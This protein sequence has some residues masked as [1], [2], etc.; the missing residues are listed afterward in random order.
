VPA[1]RSLDF[2]NYSG[3][4]IKLIMAVVAVS[5][6]ITLALVQPS[7]FEPEVVDVLFVLL[8]GT[9][10]GQ[11][12]FAAIWSALGPGAF[13]WRTVGSLLWIG[14]LTVGLYLNRGLDASFQW[15]LSRQI[16]LP[17]L[18]FWLVLQISLLT[19]AKLTAL[20]VVRPVEGTGVFVVRARQFTNR[21]LLLFIT[22]LAV[23][24]GAARFFVTVHTLKPVGGLVRVDFAV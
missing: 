17:L 15:T 7:R 3:S 5:S 8:I 1:T 11:S 20:R 6:C 14:G 21:E 18:A 12:I 4:A 13:T 19:F 22:T 24:L 9:C 10:F 23:F 16:G 2:R